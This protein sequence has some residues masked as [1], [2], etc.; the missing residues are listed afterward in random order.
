MAMCSR[1][2]A[3]GS[4]SRP[5]TVTLGAQYTFQLLGRQAFVRADDEFQS[6]R[7][8]PIPNEDPATAFYDPGLVPDQAT[9]Q[10]SLRAG[11]SLAKWDIAVFANN[12]LNSHPQLNL[13]HEDSSTL[14]YEATT[15]RPLTIGIAASVR[16]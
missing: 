15:L 12:V 13:Q 1:S 6:R 14:L 11:M 16:Y 8:K 4:I 9:N 2:R 10:L 5:L 7:T 3:T